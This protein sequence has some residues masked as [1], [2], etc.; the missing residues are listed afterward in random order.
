M[1]KTF[2][3]ALAGAYPAG[4]LERFQQLFS[5][6][7][8]IVFMLA[9]TVEKYEALT[10][11]DC[12]IL[13]VFRAERKD[14][15]RISGLKMICRWGVGFDSVDIAAA[16]EH[17]IAVCNTPGANA[18]AVSEHTVMLMLALGHNV[19]R[20]TYSLRDGIW[21]KSIYTQQSITLKDKLVGLIGGGNIS[22]QV[23]EKVQS[24]GARVQYSDI[25]RLPEDVEAKLNMR[26]A[27]LNELLKTSD[28]VSL[29]IPLTDETRHMIG[30]E[31]F[32]MMKPGAYLV[33]TARGGLINERDMLEFV[34]NGRLAGVGLDCTENE[35]IEKE[36]ALFQYPNVIITPHVAGTSS[37][38]GDAIIPMI[39][40][41]IRKLYSGEP[42]DYVVNEF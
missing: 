6:N 31:Q 4:T 34:Q 13:R 28:I 18:H 8:N 1:K 2:I 38:I 23:A 3:A 19:M 17:G 12:M 22:R 37:D 36:H 39:E 11:A 26:Y 7:E 35:P 14:I 33:N 25:N 20:H 41:N 21:S 15:E 42:L 9:D 16:G 32:E 10:A 5:D 24:F 29:H 30:R 40:S 27:G